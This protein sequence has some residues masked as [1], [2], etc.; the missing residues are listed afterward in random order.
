MHFSTWPKVSVMQFSGSFFFVVLVVVFFMTKSTHRSIVYLCFWFIAIV[1]DIALVG[2]GFYL[3]P[4][5]K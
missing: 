2:M 5:F 3:H 4:L 1:R